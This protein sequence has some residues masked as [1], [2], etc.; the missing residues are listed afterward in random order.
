[1]SGPSVFFGWTAVRNVAPARTWS[2]DPSPSAGN[3][4][5]FRS[6][7]TTTTLSLNGVSGP[8]IGGRSKPV[9]VDTGVQLCMIMPLGTYTTPRR[10]TLVV[11]AWPA[12]ANA[13]TIASSNG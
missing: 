13:G 2:P 4:G 1:M 11:A 8:R 7:V 5:W 3:A 9:P 12:G 10:G 6:P